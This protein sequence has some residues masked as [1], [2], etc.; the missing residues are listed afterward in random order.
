MA[1]PKTPQPSP[2][3]PGVD[4]EQFPLDGEGKPMVKI[5]FAAHELIGLPN[6]SNVT[7][8]PVRVEAF[9]PTDKPNPFTEQQL[10]N[11]ASGIQ[12]LAETV[13]FDVIAPQRKLVLDSLDPSKN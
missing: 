13:E 5:A 9:I 2:A 4:E 12:Q 8:G 11:I 7:I 1:A 6:F 3:A 10:R